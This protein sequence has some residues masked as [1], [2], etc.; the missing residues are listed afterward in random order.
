M[1]MKHCAPNHLLVYKDGA[2]FKTRVILSLKLLLILLYQLIMFEAPS[3]NS[4]WD[5]LNKIFHS[6]P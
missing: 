4:F 5:I 6:D 3:Y 1:F 2:L